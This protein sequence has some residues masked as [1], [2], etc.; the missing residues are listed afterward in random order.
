MERKKAKKFSIFV[1]H[2]SQI[3]LWLL[4]FFLYFLRTVF[5]CTFYDCHRSSTVSYAHQHWR[6]VRIIYSSLS[7]QLD[8]ME[9]T[10]DLHSLHK[11]EH[12]RHISWRLVSVQDDIPPWLKKINRK[13]NYHRNDWKIRR[14]Q[15]NFFLKIFLYR[16]EEI[17]E[18]KL[19]KCLSR[20]LKLN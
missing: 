6:N 12:V 3:H 10:A 16:I 18:K 20:I 7:P 9:R 1:N 15:A 19:T 14:S 11:V 17:Q 4:F 13:L 5:Y 2:F 8:T